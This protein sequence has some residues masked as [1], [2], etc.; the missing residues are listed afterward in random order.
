[1][2]VCVS[3]Y[4][5]DILCVYVCVSMYLSCSETQ[6]D[7]AHATLTLRP[8][9][10]GCT[11]RHS[12]LGASLP[13]SCSFSLSAPLPLS[14]GLLY[15][16]R[17]GEEQL[18]GYPVKT[19]RWMHNG[20]VRGGTLRGREGLLIYFSPLTQFSCTWRSSAEHVICPY[21]ISYCFSSQ[22]CLFK[23]CTVWYSVY[24]SKLCNE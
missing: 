9:M 1:M 6:R 8:S 12:S 17:G 4:L 2:C 19:E 24:S 13:H 3:A 7:A 11:H 5:Y 14:W 21:G 15:Q 22:F 10:S 23:S 20:S 18:A 16:W